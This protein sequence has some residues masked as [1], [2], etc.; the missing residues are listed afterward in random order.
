[1]RF[2]D[3]LDQD[4][5]HKHLE[6]AVKRYEKAAGLLSDLALHLFAGWW[7]QNCADF[8]NFG[9]MEPN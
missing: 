8:A 7:L 1:M 6:E 4:D 2:E 5:E 3:D 9:K